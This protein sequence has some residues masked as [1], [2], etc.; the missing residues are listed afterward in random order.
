MSAGRLQPTAAAVENN[1]HLIRGQ[2]VMLD[3]DLARLYGV[4]TKVLIQATKRNK[5][6]FP[7]DFMFQLTAAEWKTLR[8]QIVTSKTGRGGRRYLPYVFTEHGAVMLA[9]VLN[10]DRAIQA[11]I[12]V[13]RVFVRMRNMLAAHKEFAR[14]LSE[15]EKRVSGH[16]QDIKAIVTA[17][18]QIMRPAKPP[19]RRIGFE[20]KE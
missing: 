7:P 5:E 8:S 18:R 20:S 15:L 17:I 9:S 3:S 10:S 16:D 11:S 12:V 19:G 14:K 13:V 4:Q 2:R 1:I 6:R